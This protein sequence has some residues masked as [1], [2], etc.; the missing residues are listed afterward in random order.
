[1]KKT[2]DIMNKVVGIVRL[3]S[4]FEKLSCPISI[5]GAKLGSCKARKEDEK[6]QH[7][8]LLRKEIREK[9]TFLKNEVDPSMESDVW[10]L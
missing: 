3:R 8:C 4:E 6:Y 1:M 10:S 2:M 7:L 5:L 9:I